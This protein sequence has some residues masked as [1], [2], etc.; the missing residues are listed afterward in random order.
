M[1]SPS[2]SHPQTHPLTLTLP[3]TLTLSPSPSPSHPP[4]APSGQH[5]FEQIP[6]MISTFIGQAIQVLMRPAHL[7]YLRVNTFLLQRSHLDVRDI[8]MFYT[9]LQVQG[10][11]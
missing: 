11:G 4:P 8:P 10:D 7:L 3:P 2:P 5:A 6:S 9:L 1:P